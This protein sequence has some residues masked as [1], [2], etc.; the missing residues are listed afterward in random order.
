MTEQAELAERILGLAELARKMETEREKVTPH[1]EPLGAQ[2]GAQEAAEETDMVKSMKKETFETLLDDRDA[3]LPSPYQSSVC[4]DAGG[5]VRRF[6]QLDRFWKKFN[7]VLLDKLAI[8]N[9]RNRLRD[10]N[11]ALQVRPIGGAGQH[12]KCM[13]LTCFSVPMC[14]LV[15]QRFL[16]QYI[17]GV[18]VNDSVLNTAGNPLLV[19]NG[20]VNLNRPLPVRLDKEALTVVDGNHMVATNRVNNP[21]PL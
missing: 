17:D 4:E 9:E 21:R 19:I 10:E 5:P 8:E 1:H 3:P 15:T 6:N 2:E 18:S 20:Q 7:K 12:V 16:K 11:E 14:A 13:V